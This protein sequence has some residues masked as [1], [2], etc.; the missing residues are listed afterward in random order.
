MR[1]TVL[2]VDDEQFIR[3]L[4]V[5]SI[6]REGYLV[7]EACDGREALEVLRESN[8]DIVISDIKM[9]NMDGWQLLEEIK[10]D[11]PDVSVILITAYAGDHTPEHAIEAGADY[12]ITKPFKNVEIA[13]T[14]TGLM[15]RRRKLAAAKNRT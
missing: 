9:P 6:K 1:A 15:N 4:L 5:R 12:F 7:S 14:L 8:V 10:K 2:V 11:Y 3:Q 13:R